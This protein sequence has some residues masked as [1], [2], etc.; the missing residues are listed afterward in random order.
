MKLSALNGGKAT[1]SFGEAR[2]YLKRGKKKKREGWNS[3]NQY[4]QLA[5]KFLR[6]RQKA[7]RNC[8]L[9]A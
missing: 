3:K 9:Q 5:F 7:G 4:I 6:Q 1:F 8:E 2:K